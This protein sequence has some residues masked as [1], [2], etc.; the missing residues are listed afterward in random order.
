MLDQRRYR[1]SYIYSDAND[2]V[3]NG[4]VSQHRTKVCPKKSKNNRFSM[5]SDGSSATSSG[6]VSDKMPSF[7]EN[8]G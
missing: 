1:E 8:E 6:I 3:A 5:I 7:D 4:V 2:L